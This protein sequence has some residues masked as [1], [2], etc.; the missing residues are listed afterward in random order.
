[1]LANDDAAFQE[2][3]EQI[4]ERLL[5]VLEKM[6]PEFRRDQVLAFQ[7]ARARN[8]MALPTLNYSRSL[9]PAQTS[10]PGVFVVN[11][12]QI[13]KGNL[14]VNETIEVAD[15]AMPQLTDYLQRKTVG[16]QLTPVPC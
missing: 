14:N 13:T 15:M 2:S 6:Y 11:S 10:V 4:R 16:G 7:T 8:V 9:P 5:G 1:V 12:A 3:D